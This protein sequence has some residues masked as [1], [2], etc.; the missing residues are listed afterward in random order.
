MRSYAYDPETFVK[1]NKTIVS[2]LID[3]YDADY[4]YWQRMYEV[5]KELYKSKK[6]E[7]GMEVLKRIYHR[8]P[9]LE[10]KVTILDIATPHTLKRYTNS[11]RGAYMSFLF[12]KRNTM[13]VSSGKIAG[14]KN[15]YLSGQWVSSPGGL[16]FA[17]VT[18]YYAIQR[19][20]KNENLSYILSP[21]LK[22][23]IE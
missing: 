6:E 9:E 11:K 3:Q 19:I 14:L 22:T 4:F 20:C 8:F 5:D 23:K 2:C 13:Y 12:T 10:G 15:L 21:K 16:P 7:I 18:G 1:D 17:M